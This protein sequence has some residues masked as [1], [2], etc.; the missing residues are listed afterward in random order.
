MRFRVLPLAEP[1]APGEVLVTVEDL[2]QLREH[3]RAR[4]NFLYHVTHELRT[5][6]TNIHAYAETLTKPGFDDEQTRKECYN[7]L[8]SETQR[9]SRLVEDILSME[10]LEAGGGGS[11]SVK[12]ILGWSGV[13][14]VG[15]LRKGGGEP[16]SAEPGTQRVPGASD[17]G[18]KGGRVGQSDEKG[19]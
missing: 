3:E 4:D 17:F 16:A 7:V 18:E 1:S 19:V 8:I 2:S 5:P 9:L 6:L 13:V 10:D 14:I 11:L 12:V 15:R